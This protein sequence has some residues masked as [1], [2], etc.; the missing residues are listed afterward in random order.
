MPRWKGD[1]LK[2][3]DPAPRPEPDPGADWKRKWEIANGPAGIGHLAG[4][5][6]QTCMELIRG[7]LVTIEHVRTAY[8]DGKLGDVKGIGRK[9][10][11]EI[12]LALLQAGS[13]V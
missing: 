10:I 6:H 2:V 1:E 5:S 12:Q 4:I 7:G 8:L 11:Q 13:S 3:A 9:R